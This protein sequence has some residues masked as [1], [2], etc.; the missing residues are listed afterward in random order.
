MKV[1]KKYVFFGPL[2]KWMMSKDR[3][4]NVV[5]GMGF[6]RRKL[7]KWLAVPMGRQQWR[8]RSSTNGTIGF[9]RVERT[10]EMTHAAAVQRQRRRL[11]LL[12]KDR[13]ITIREIVDRIDC[14]YGTVFRISH[15]QLNMRRICA[16]WIPKML[17]DDQKRI[18]VE[19][20][21]RLLKR[22]ER[23]GADFMGKIFT[24]DET[25]TRLYTPETKAQSTMWKT[26]AHRLRRS[27]S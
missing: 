11:T 12:D 16:R 20:C 15:D 24:V 1:S 25:W 6:L 18:T 10:L 23:E 2:L 22:F 19:S 14:G 3:L 21:K 9:R 8:R 17:T 7:L 26:P 5:C 4:S 27:S 13:R